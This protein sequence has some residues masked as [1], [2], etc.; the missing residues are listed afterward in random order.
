V[1]TVSR[2]A[3]TS[4]VIKRILP[5]RREEVF[6]AWL[7]ADSLSDWMRPAQTIRQTTAEIDPRVGGRYRIVMH[8]DGRD[9]DHEGEYLLIDRPSRLSFTWIS[10]GTERQPSIVTIELFDRDGKTEL[11]LTHSQLPATQVGPHTQ[12]WGE[13]VDMLARHLST[14][15]EKRN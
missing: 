6:D 9:Y 4:L 5:A 3:P 8:G 1:T 11:V 10:A 7:N 15:A 12:G 2:N 14:R 13:I